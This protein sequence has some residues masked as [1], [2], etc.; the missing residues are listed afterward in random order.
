MTHQWLR[1]FARRYFP[2][3]PARRPR[4]GRSIPCL[5]QV[6]SLESRQSPTTFTVTTTADSGPGSLRQAI[7]DANATQGSNTIAFAIG[8][9]GVQTIRPTSALPAITNP[10]LL[11]GTSQPGFSGSPLIVLDGGAAGAGANGLK[12]LTG[13]S[14]LQA[15]VIDGFQ[16]AGIVL[17]GSGNQITADYLGVDVTG[18]Q[19]AGNA[20]AGI[21][22]AGG[23]NN[24]IG[25][26]TAGAGNVIAF[27][28]RDGVLVRGG[29]GNAI[30]GNAI[31]SN[32]GAGIDLR[33]GA[34]Q[35]QAYPQVTTADTTGR[36]VTVAGTLSSAPTTAYR[37]EF[38]ANTVC[39]PSGYGDGARFLGV[40][41]A[42]TDD[43]GTAAFAATFAAGVPAGQYVTA[44]ATDPGGNTSSFSPCVAV[45]VPPTVVTNTNDSGAGSLRQA[46]ADTPEGGT[47][48]FDAA[49]AGQTITLT[50]G[51]L[52]ITRSV[53]IEGPGAGQLTISGHQ[54]SRVFDISQSG[55]TVTIAGVTIAN[56]F[57]TGRVANG[58]GIF[59]AGGR[60]EIDDC[61]LANNQG[62]GASGVGVG[63]GGSGKGGAIYS[64][65]GTVTI[66]RS[67]LVNNQAKGGIGN[68][69]R[70]G[71]GSP[72][73]VGEGGAIYVAGGQLE[74]H[75]ST[76]AAN[77]AAGGAGGSGNPGAAGA[78]GMGGGIYVANASL[79]VTDSTFTANLAIGGEGG[80]RIPMGVGTAGSG[81]NGMGGGLGI[82]AGTVA[83]SESTFAAD[84]ATGGTGGAGVNFAGAP[85]GNGMGGGLD[86][87]GGTVAVTDSTL[88]TNRATGGMGGSGS[89]G[90]PAGLASGNGITNAGAITI[91][92]T[93]VAANPL[94]SAPDVSGILHSLGHNLIGNGTGGSGFTDTDLVGTAAN[95]IDPQ[96][97]PLG[98][99]GGPTQTLRP[100]P[101]SP[102]V[103]AGDNT[104]APDTDQRG[105][106]R[107]VNGA[108][109]IGAVELQPG[110]RGGGAP[111]LSRHGRAASAVATEV[112]EVISALVVGRP[113]VLP[114]RESTP[115]PSAPVARLTSDRGSGSVGHHPLDSFFQ[116]RESSEQR[117]GKD[118]PTLVALAG[119][120]RSLGDRELAD[121]AFIEEWLAGSPRTGVT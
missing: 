21:R 28:G 85:G 101:S 13:Q 114:V 59:V 105:F 71:P 98:D 4:R 41:T 36:S 87:A 20:G 81:G 92:N 9:G 109:D 34:N 23:S 30:L 77:Q 6:E 70:G 97:E 75:E 115:P 118:P 19:A 82:A 76:F 95:P 73:G 5:P 80:T 54:T 108:I 119:K 62:V 104:D 40:G 78:L 44:T 83:V 35:G 43:S 49:L 100:L 26:R 22:I 60:V 37:L 93:I 33:H 121:L 51:E 27:N 66:N 117:D 113:Q 90:G 64:A 8:Q 10:V 57:T 112:T 25:G 86:I 106:D 29:S 42:T 17:R 63:T 11:D 52:A 89:P 45:V 102:A 56:G 18:S 55:L 79:A 94:P 15:L 7:L 69:F 3:Q 110:E 96:L 116:P 1:S 72:G 107:I 120:P 46:L 58:G 50:S 67:T 53:A 61:A 99:Y 16:G 39:N 24:T 91:R 68:Y 47:I 74:I 2:F 111:R 103:D 88:S 38:F 12:L 32:T 14:T 48:R 31:V 65:G 84:Q